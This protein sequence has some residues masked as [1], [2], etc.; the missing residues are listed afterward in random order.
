MGMDNA[1]LVGVKEDWCQAH[2]GASLYNIELLGTSEYFR[3]V[4]GIFSSGE[5]QRGMEAD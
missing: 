3:Q 1:L 2:R 5:K 4:S